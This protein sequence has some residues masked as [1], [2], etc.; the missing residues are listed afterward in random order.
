M[1]LTLI[2]IGIVLIAVSLVSLVYHVHA[3]GDGGGSRS[4][5]GHR[6]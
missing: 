6:G 5:Q 2:I 4:H 3:P 1:A